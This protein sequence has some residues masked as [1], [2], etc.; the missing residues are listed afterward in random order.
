MSRTST[1]ALALAALVMLCTGP[2]SGAGEEQADDPAVPSYVRP[3][4]GADEEAPA[5]P[6]GP[7]VAVFPFGNHTV[8]HDLD[9]LVQ[10]FRQILNGHGERNDGIELIPQRVVDRAIRRVGYNPSRFVPLA[11]IHAVARDLGCDYAVAGFFFDLQEEYGIRGIVLRLPKEQRDVEEFLWPV[12]ALFPK[13]DLAQA[14]E[15]AGRY[16]AD[17]ATLMGVLGTQAPA[18]FHAGQRVRLR[19]VTQADRVLISLADP[20]A[21]MLAGLGYRIV[22]GRQVSEVTVHPSVD[23][24][25]GEISIANQHPEGTRRRAVVDIHI[26]IATAEDSFELGVNKVGEGEVRLEVHNE[27]RLGEPRLVQA[28]EVDETTT[29]TQSVIAME[30]LRRDGPAFALA[31]EFGPEEG[32][33]ELATPED[34]EA[35]GAEAE[36]PTV[37]PGEDEPEGDTQAG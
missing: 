16:W 31:G 2:V 9:Y 36:G 14:E 7:R 19:V 35:P 22:E 28:I 24:G 5:E 11:E 25:L 37:E 15:A 32:S 18:S 13:S 17:C 1:C 33:I 34:L 4:Q 6:A 26:V 21:V 10:G 20:T 3:E 12:L 29:A 27:N 23:G 30:P 8:S